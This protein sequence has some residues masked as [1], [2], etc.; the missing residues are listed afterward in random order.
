[1]VLA[2]IILLW[3]L[4]AISE[5]LPKLSFEAIIKPVQG[6][7]IRIMVIAY[8]IYLPYESLEH[9]EKA[10]TILVYLISNDTSDAAQVFLNLQWHA[11]SIMGT[12]ILYLCYLADIFFIAN[13]YKNL[14]PLASSH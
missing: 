5:K 14:H 11:F 6:N 7:I 9:I 8:L 13:V 4:I 1:M 10:L 3:P 12:V 2:A